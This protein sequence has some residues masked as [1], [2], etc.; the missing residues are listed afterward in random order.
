MH[1]AVEQAL[2]EN[3]NDQQI[4]IQPVGNDADPQNQEGEEQ[5]RE[6]FDVVFIEDENLYHNELYFLQI[7]GQ[8]AF[9]T[10]FRGHDARKRLVALKRID[11][12]QI[13]DNATLETT[14]N[15]IN[16]FKGLK[17]ENIVECYD[18]Y[19]EHTNGRNHL[20]LVLEYISG[21]DLEQW[22]SMKTHPLMALIPEV[23]IWHIFKQI[24]SAVEFIHSNR[25]IHRDLKPANVLIASRTLVKLTDFGLSRLTNHASGAK[26]V[27]G[28]P[29]YMAPERISETGYSFFSDI[30]SL[31]CI[32]YEMAALKSP[33]FGEKDNITS[34]VEKVKHSDY[35]PIPEDCYSEQMSMLID[36]CMSPVPSDRP[37]ASDVRMI[38]FEMYG[39]NSQQK[40]TARR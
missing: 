7:I 26:T 22:I 4:E 17:H 6:H 36:A 3:E 19:E 31:G 16:L 2:D 20:V 32:L 10:V 27:C 9:A 15:E 33:F 24:A 12:S 23:E 1:P 35:P 18:S 5:T 21:G 37:R 39:R 38:A 13:S 34:L 40:T 28:T 11:L 25:I 8:G 14:L 29:Y 30:W